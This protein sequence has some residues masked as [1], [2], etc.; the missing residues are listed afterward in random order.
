MAEKG[1][2]LKGNAKLKVELG[3]GEAKPWAGEISQ[4]YQKLGSSEKGLS[5]E[6]SERRIL[7]C[8]RN[9]IPKG[10]KGKGLRIFLSQFKNAFFLILLFAT[11][12]S[13]SFHENIE[14]IVILIM[15]GINVT[16]GFW[17][18]YK[19]EKTIEALQKYISVRAKVMRGGKIIDID[20]KEI[21]PGDIVYLDIGDIVPADMRLIFAEGMNSDE[22]VLTGESMPVDK[23]AKGNYAKYSIPQDIKN[24]AFMGTSISSGYGRGIVVSTGKQTFFGKTAV[25][26]EEKSEGDFQKNIKKFSRMLMWIVIGMILVIFIINSIL[27]KGILTS[28]LFALA[29]A[30]GITPELLPAILTISFSKGALRMAKEKVIIKKLA[31][32]EDLGNMDILCCDKT[33]TLTEGKLS[34]V[35]Y[36]KFDDVQEKKLLLYSMLCNSSTSLRGT[37]NPIDRAIWANSEVEPLKR[38]YIKYKILDRSEFDFERRRMSVLVSDK[39][40]KTLIV[41]GASESILKVSGF[42]DENG[43]KAVLSSSRLAKI[44]EKV[45]SYEK[46]GYRIILI[47]EKK[48]DKIK[49]HKEDENG[50][51]VLGLLLFMDPPKKETRE[52]L[53]EFQKLKVDIKVL[54][55]DSPLVTKKV[56][57]EVG[58]E[59]KGKVIDGEELKKLSQKKFEEYC[60]GYNVFARIDPEQKHRIVKFLSNSHVVGYLGDGINDVPALKASSVGISVDSGT[61]IAKD[62][63]DVIM[64]QRNLLVLARGIIEGRKTFANI[65]KYMIN[66]ISS[67]YGSVFSI[68]ASSL[69]LKFIPMLPS[70]ILLGNLL[71]DVPDLTISSDNVDS[72]LLKKPGKWNLRSIYKSMIYFGLLSSFFDIVLIFTLL[73]MGVNVALFRTSW[74]VESFIAEI[75][76][77]FSLR[78]A[79]PFFKSK[80]SRLISLV[81]GL[82]IAFGII[83]TYLA[84]GKDLFEFAAMPLWILVLI[85]GVLVAYFASAEI[86]KKKFFAEFERQ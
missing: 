2:E 41:K 47:A 20:S 30:V 6:E 5:S 31:S 73:L 63:A 43:R 53:E 38:E 57:E 8:G 9:E 70:Q 10:N 83:I 26:A 12:V 4:L 64:L 71:S 35:R 62:A 1:V 46:E 45:E 55:G 17:Q 79:R 22:S 60:L 40:A 25:F 77:F 75:I 33:G 16:M 21:V 42:V 68:A 29:L 37:D 82:S 28:L 32:I 67:N 11:I 85:V 34:L 19:A 24:M 52:A 23:T 27:G 14:A 13:F 3:A 44:R 18:E 69:F 84:F 59:I 58:L 86:L 65:N 80:P 72:E 50:L 36:L 54:S 51:V 49:I 74:F 15:V 61:E 66:T 39:N 56:C 81:A 48:L 76:V 7:S 78:T